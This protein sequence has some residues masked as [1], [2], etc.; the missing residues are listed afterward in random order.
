MS[1]NF[2]GACYSALASSYSMPDSGK[3]VISPKMKNK[4][5]KQNEKYPVGG[6]DLLRMIRDA[7]NEKV[8][9]E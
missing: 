3:L 7:L 4:I 2:E 9:W 1:L 6:Q 8:T 5:R